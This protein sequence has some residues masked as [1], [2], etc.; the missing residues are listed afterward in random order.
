MP[1]RIL[2]YVGMAMLLALLVYGWSMPPV[3]ASGFR[4][5]QTA[6]SIDW[7]ARGFPV[8]S[9]ITP[10]IG[11]PWAIPFEFPLYQWLAA[12]L[13]SATG[14]EVGNSARLVSALFHLGCIG[15]VYRLVLVI[16]PDRALALCIAGA[17]AVSPYALFWG[18]SVMIESTAV[19]FGL[20][21]VWALALLRE[22]PQGAARM[23]GL[24][25]LAVVAAMLSALVKVTTFFGFAAFVALG[26]A[27]LA[28]REQGWRPQWLARHWPM[29][30]WGALSALAVLAV[31]MQWLSH[32][33]ALKAQS[34]LGREVTSSALSTWNYGTLQQKLDPATWWGT[35]FKKR[36]S[37]AVGSNWVFLILLVVGL[38]ARPIRAAVALL[39][40]AYLAPV[41]VFTN[42][43]IAHPYYQAATIVF[44]TSI[45][46]L[47]VWWTLQ[48]A[49]ASGKTSRPLW[50]VGLLCLLSLANVGGNYAKRMRE[51]RVPGEVAQI[52]ALI[53]AG[54]P[55]Q[56]VVVAFGQ[57]WSSEL[58]Y[59][60]SRR[61]VMVPDWA[62][63]SALASMAATDDALG[64]LPIGAL[65]N[66]PNAIG[67]DAQR[68]ALQQQ[69]IAR[70]S[71]GIAARSVGQ[72]QVW[73]HP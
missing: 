72:C 10:V 9:Y 52:A 11:A 16:R 32:A 56:G 23:I 30:A 50:L 20:V 62:P 8:L 14:M 39:L 36:F 7:M 57:D 35:V 33:D 15:V 29:L 61:A 59:L 41:A 71:A 34:P 1:G 31:L 46:G 67:S 47:V 43:H 69:I 17:F 48:R 24:G 5:T 73:L 42:L 22:R 4:Q 54:T 3:D 68:S 60:S 65:V 25:L 26:V 49:Q 12:M 64:G 19:F 6:L 13:V 28:L 53:K 51:A 21:F 37:G 45:V 44:A 40:V 27:W 66:C 18:R 58:P 63:T 70:Y 38:C 55:A 2:L